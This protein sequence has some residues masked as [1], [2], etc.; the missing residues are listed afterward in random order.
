MAKLNGV[1]LWQT[2]SHFRQNPMKRLFLTL[3]L[4]AVTFTSAV[5]QSDLRDDQKAICCFDLQ[6]E[7]LLTSDLAKTIGPEAMDQ[8]K[9]NMET[10]VSPEKYKRIYGFVG[11]NNMEE[12]MSMGPQNAPK[13]MESWLL[14]DRPSLFKECELLI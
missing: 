3:L 5:A 2:T 4:A 12:V 13:V 11:A 8:I 7:K 14:G 1:I 10:P 9:R 6:V